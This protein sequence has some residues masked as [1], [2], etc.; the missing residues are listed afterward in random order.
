MAAS[1]ATEAENSLSRY[2]WEYDVFLSFRGAD[3]RKKLVSHLN[4]ALN[5]EGIKTFHDDRDLQRGDVIWEALE[6]AINQSRFA[7][8]V[9]SEGYADSHWCLRE[10]SLMV[11]LAEKKRLQLIPIFYE[12]DPSNLKSRT[13]C[14]SKA[15]EK[16][17]PRFGKE[18]V[19]PW[20]SALATVGNISGWDSKCRNED[21]KLVQNVVQDLRDR[22]Y[23]EPEP[24]DERTELDEVLS[25]HK[26][27][28]ES[29]LS[30]D[31]EDVQM[32]GV[33][34]VDGK[35]ITT[36]TKHIFEGLSSQFPARCF[37]QDVSGE[38][39]R[40]GVSHL[41]KQIMS[42]VFPKSP[43]N[44]LCISKDAVKRRLRGKKVLL[45][46]DDVDDVEQLQELAGKC[47]WFGP[48]S[49]II[50]T[51]GYERVLEEH[52]VERIHEVTSQA[53]EIISDIFDM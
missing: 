52:S 6:E 39:Q 24:S 31:S 32:V 14:F 28:I 11:D 51:T 25:Y 10:L 8:V 15:F 44:A 22:L 19:K 18:T 53:I 9:I 1:L 43:L 47:E 36:I 45:V 29:L 40:H 23:S 2:L 13:G 3:V 33:W 16:H 12:I 42:E 46:L 4:D 26:R 48:G 27:C 34:G 30:M 50:I 37:L 49:R 41:R 5:E 35:D 21:S 7:I 17:E 20:R 38:L